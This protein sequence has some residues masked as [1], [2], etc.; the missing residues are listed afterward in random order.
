MK[1]VLVT[2]LPSKDHPVLTVLALTVTTLPS[3]SRPSDLTLVPV[4]SVLIL[5]L[6]TYVV[7]ALLPIILAPKLSYLYYLL[8]NYYHG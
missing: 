3:V 4:P 7:L 6:S 2:L 8:V 5:K 1:S